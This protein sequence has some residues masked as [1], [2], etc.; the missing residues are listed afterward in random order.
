METLNYCVDGEW[1]ESATD[2]YLPV[3]DS[4]T[5]EVYRPSPVLHRG[6]G[7]RGHRVGPRGLRPVVRQAGRRSAP[8][9][10]SRGGR[11][12]RSTWRRSPA[13]SRPSSA[14]TSTRP[15]A[16]SSRS[17]RR[18]SVAVGAPMLMK[19]ESLMNVSTGHDTVSYREP[20]GVF[21]GIAPF[22]FPAMIPFGWMIPLCIATRQHLGAQG[23]PA[24]CRITSHPAARP[25][26]RRPA[27]PRASSTSS[28]AR[29]NEAEILLKHPLVRGVSFVG[30][31]AAS[32][33]T[34]TPSPP[35]TASGSRR[36]PRPRTTASCCATPRSSGPPAASS[37][38][39]SAAPACAAWRCRCVV[40]EDAVADEFVGYMKQFAQ[41][42]IVGCAY[43]PKTELGPVVSA[44]HQTVRHCAGSTRASRR[45]PSSS[46]TGATSSSRASRGGHFVGPTIFDH[47]TEDMSCGR[48]EVFG[49]VLFIK[50]VDRLRRGPRH[51]ERQPLR[52]RLV[53]LHRE[54]LLLAASSRAARTPAWSASTWAS[55]CRWP[56]SR[57]PVTRQSFFGDNH[58]LGMDG[59]NFFTETKC[60]TTRWFTEADKKATNV[61]TWEGTVNRS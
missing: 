55:R 34:S 32:A 37:T 16:R 4:S 18:A 44:E 7:H 36:R 28:P 39:P 21:A 60:V 54:R 25:A 30:S 22:N 56:S 61:S 59:V 41:E 45:A 11:S 13:W 57:S 1:R 33:C 14:R 53:H 24:W 42:R 46:S 49:P 38:P 31:D 19:G 29:R 23:A 17:S 9:C 35:R 6:R 10:S 52:Q 43:D 27:C 8:R 3:T 26:A 12:S 51:H 50:R 40:V 47:V 15:A 20:L 48:E 2:M 58:V 5:G